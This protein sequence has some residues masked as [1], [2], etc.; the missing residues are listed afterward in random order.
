MRKLT[1]QEDQLE[2]WSF[3]AHIPQNC[4]RRSYLA[5]FLVTQ[6]S[7]YNL[8]VSLWTIRLVICRLWW[9]Y[10]S[11]EV[12]CI[13]IVRSVNRLTTAFV[14][15]FSCATWSCVPGWVLHYASKKYGACTFNEGHGDKRKTD[16]TVCSQQSKKVSLIRRPHMS[17]CLWRN[18]WD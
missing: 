7:T 3:P 4:V 10:L 16:S 8:T 17:V 15:L 9:D 18:I 5:S 13:L 2:V 14:D 6:H 12:I 1:N 11:Y